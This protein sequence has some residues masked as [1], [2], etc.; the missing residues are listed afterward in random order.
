M[1]LPF[2][3]AHPHPFV[4]MEEIKEGSGMAYVTR[5]LGYLGYSIL[6]T[7]I[8]DQEKSVSFQINENETIT[9]HANE[10]YTFG[11]GSLLVVTKMQIENG[12]DVM[13]Y[14]FSATDEAPVPLHLNAALNEL[15]P[16]TT[17]TSEGSIN[18]T[19]LAVSKMNDGEPVLEE[20]FRALLAANGTQLDASD[21]VL[22]EHP[23]YQRFWN[24]LKSLF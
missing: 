14:A 13:H 3:A 10:L 4:V 23:W 5:G 22:V 17:E 19:M 8:H 20:A 18:G 12:P 16:L 11:D 7:N 6:V 21:P 9:L 24:W 15:A 1:A 2:A